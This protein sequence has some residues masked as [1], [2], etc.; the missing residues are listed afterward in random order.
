MNYPFPQTDHELAQKQLAYLG[1]TSNE[2]FLRFFY[3]SDN[4]KKG[5]DKGRKLNVLDWGAI[6][7]HQQ[8]ERGTYVVVNGA[9]GG[10]E[11][12]DIKQCAAIFCEWDDRPI[13]DQLLHWETLGFFEPTFTVY[14]GDK[15]AQPY[16]VFDTPINVEQWRELQRLLIEVMGADPSNKNP[17][18]VFRLAGGW[19]VKPGREPRRTEI[20]QESGQKYPYEQLKERLQSLAKPPMEQAT[21]PITSTLSY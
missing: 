18:R 20:V 21:R 3:H 1:Y 4:P 7:S 19:H 8:D 13:E 5:D 11:D 12:K 17:S 14:S 6:S 15:S 2:V 10:H 9:G 16:W